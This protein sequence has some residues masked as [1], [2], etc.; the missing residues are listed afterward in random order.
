MNSLG[1]G[2]SPGSS[3]ANGAQYSNLDRP[4]QTLLIH[5]NRANQQD[6]CPGASCGTVAARSE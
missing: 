6:N 5:A 4:C 1:L 2:Y 3:G